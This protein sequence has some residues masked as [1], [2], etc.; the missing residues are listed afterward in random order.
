MAAHFLQKL[1]RSEQFDIEM[2]KQDMSALLN[3][4]KT[5]STGVGYQAHQKQNRNPFAGRVNPFA[6]R[7]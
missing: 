2:P 7:R 6:R 1:R 3:A 4:G 5:T